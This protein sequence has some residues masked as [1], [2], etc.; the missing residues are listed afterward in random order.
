[1]D[2]FLKENESASEIKSITSIVQPKDLLSEQI[3]DLMSGIKA[4][5]ECTLLL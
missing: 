5:E 4:R 2:K 3:L 1:M